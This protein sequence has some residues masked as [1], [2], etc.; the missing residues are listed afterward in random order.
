MTQR[1]FIRKHKNALGCVSGP[2]EVCWCD[3][4][5]ELSQIWN[6]VHQDIADS[7]HARVCTAGKTDSQKAR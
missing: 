6:E 2:G 1:D 7:I 5:R 3:V 4:C